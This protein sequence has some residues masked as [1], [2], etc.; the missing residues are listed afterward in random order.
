MAR[1]LGFTDFLKNPKSSEVVG[2]KT[3]TFHFTLK[4]PRGDSFWY[5]I[6]FLSVIIR[7]DMYIVF[8]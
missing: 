2:G 4:H 8:A 5:H 3:S 7:I 6:F 1:G